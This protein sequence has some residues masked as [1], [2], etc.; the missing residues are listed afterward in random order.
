MRPSYSR[1]CFLH[2][3]WQSTGT[4]KAPATPGEDRSAPKPGATSGAWWSNGRGLTGEAHCQAQLSSRTGM[5]DWW[6]GAEYVSRLADLTARL[7]IS[8]T[9]S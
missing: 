1:N 6:M 9:F 2:C 7:A 8:W 5:L 3:A 4:G